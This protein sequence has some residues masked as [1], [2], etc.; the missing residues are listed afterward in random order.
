[1]IPARWHMT[2]ID[3]SQHGEAQTVASPTADADAFRDPTKTTRIVKAMLWLSIAL[4][5]VAVGSDLLQLGLLQGFQDGTVPSE[6]RTALADANDLRQ[7]LIAIAQITT[8][9]VTAI[10]FSRWIYIVN[11]NKR[12][13]G[14]SGLRFSPGW[15]IGWFF[16]PIAALWMPYRAMKEVW[17]VSAN[18]SQWRQQR[19]GFVLPCWWFVWLL[20][21]V[22]DRISSS[23]TSWATKIP[24]LMAASFVS[25]ISDAT[26]VV[27]GLL[28]LMV[29][30][31][32]TRMQRDRWSE[33]NLTRHTPA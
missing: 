6:Q 13:L 19:V 27:L 9:I 20:N 28:A 7:R 16:V 31:R 32:I 18:P 4:G 5:V 25:A 11:V 10:V 30:A 23:I 22:L 12:R 17:R 29:V 8:F 2:A 24:D 1:L 15:A 3:A 33:A 21:A 26:G 14:A